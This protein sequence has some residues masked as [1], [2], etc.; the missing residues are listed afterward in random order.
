MVIKHPLVTG[1]SVSREKETL[2]VCQERLP[3]YETHQ[4]FFDTVTENQIVID[5]AII[6]LAK[7]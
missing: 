6:K 7:C 3:L 1:H 4:K 2:S 5:M